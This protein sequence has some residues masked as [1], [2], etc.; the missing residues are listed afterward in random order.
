MYTDGISPLSYCAGGPETFARLLALCER[1]AKRS[2]IH[3]YR[4]AYRRREVAL[5]VFAFFAFLLF[6]GALFAFFA[7]LAALA[8]AG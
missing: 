7:R 5:D 2:V 3:D 8:G 6:L 4:G 1:R